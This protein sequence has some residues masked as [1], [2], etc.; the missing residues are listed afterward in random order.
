MASQ[1]SSHERYDP[2]AHLARAWPAVEVVR[3]PMSGSLLGELRYPTIALRAD[4]SAAQRRC[5]LAHELVHLE[6]GGG[7]HGPWADRE[8]ILVH[9]EAARRLIRLSELECALRDQGGD[10]DL[11]ALARA[12]DVDAYTA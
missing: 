2:W 8:E 11:A 9:A 5:T 3:E 4:S 10:A 12:L 1:L 7:S 6:R